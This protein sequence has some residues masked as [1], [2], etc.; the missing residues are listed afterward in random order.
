VE[1]DDDKLLI[2]DKPTN[3]M[4]AISNI[5]YKKWFRANKSEMNSMY[6]NYIWILV[7]LPE[8]IKLIGCK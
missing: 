6:T 8:M 4:E 3:Y 7:D 1:I 2:L 5:D